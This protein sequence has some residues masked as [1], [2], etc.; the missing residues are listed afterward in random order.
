MTQIPKDPMILYSFINMKLRDCY[1]DL[2]ELCDDLDIDRNTI[3]DT[4]KSVGFEYI[5][6]IN[7]FRNCGK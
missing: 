7:Q 5:P 1:K 4:L 3:E 6:D 2:N